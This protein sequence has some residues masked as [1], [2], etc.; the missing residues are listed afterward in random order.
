MDIA[1]VPAVLRFLTLVAFLTVLL[2]LVSDGLSE[3][4]MS[5]IEAIIE[6]SNKKNVSKYLESEWYECRNVANS[7]RSK[8]DVCY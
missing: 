1:V 5:V 7:K 4:D 6:V 2:I 8:V 3:E